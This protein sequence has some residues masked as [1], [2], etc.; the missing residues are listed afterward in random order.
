MP[1]QGCLSPDPAAQLVFPQPDKY[2][3]VSVTT[4]IFH[5]PSLTF[6]QVQTWVRRRME[7]TGGKE[8]ETEGAG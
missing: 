4:A 5:S 6:T 7:K 8:Q 3:P 1:P 2:I